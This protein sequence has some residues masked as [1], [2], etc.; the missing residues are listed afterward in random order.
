MANMYIIAK[1]LTYKWYSVGMIY[2]IVDCARHNMATCQ[3]A[4]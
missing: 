2:Y 4:D 3:G 1:N